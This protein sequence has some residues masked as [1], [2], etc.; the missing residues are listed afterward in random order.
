MNIFNVC[1]LDSNG[2]PSKIFIFS[3]NE[4]LDPNIIFSKNDL[5]EFEKYKTEYIYCSQ[6][7]YKDDN[8]RNI[9]QKILSVLKNDIT[10]DEIYL[11]VKSQVSYNI[12]TIFDNISKNSF[13]ITRPQFKQFIKNTGIDYNFDDIKSDNLIIDDLYDL[14]LPQKINIDIP[15]GKIFSSN[16]DFLFSAN[17]F[18]IFDTTNPVF[19]NTNSNNLI[20]F[21]NSLLHDYTMSNNIIYLSCAS[22]TLSFASD[23]NLST[24]YF[25]DIFFN[26][27]KKF[28][29]TN[30]IQLENNK[31]NLLKS[32]NNNITVATKKYNDQV[33]LFYSIYYN[34]NKTIDYL[35]NGVNN[36]NFSFIMDNSN[37]LPLDALFKTLHVSKNMPFIKYNPGRKTENVFRLFSNSISKNGKKM[38]VISQSDI[39][40][41]SKTIGKNGKQIAFY[42]LTKIN[43]I[44]YRVIIEL[45][46]K[47]IFNIK[48]ECDNYFDVN[49][50][51]EITSSTINPII[52]SINN[53]IEQYGY[54]LNYYKTH[55]DHEI[56]VNNIDF[57]KSIKLV[58]A[59]QFK[60][61]KNF[62]NTLFTTIDD[63][64]PNSLIDFTYKRVSNFKQTD[65]IKKKIY[66]MFNGY[67]SSVIVTELIDNFKITED[68]AIQHI[69]EFENTFN[70]IDGRPVNN[71][72]KIIE[73]PG[74]KS[75]ISFIPSSDEIIFMI[76]DIDSFK[77][78]EQLNIY[79]DSI[80]RVSQYYDSITL[81]KKVLDNIN[82]KVDTEIIEDQPISDL[83][84]V[85]K[86]LIFKKINM[87]SDDI[88]NTNKM[89]NKDIDI[90]N[91]DEDDDDDEGGIL[92]DEDDD[93]NEDDD[94]DEGGILFDDDD[95]EDNDEMLGGTGIKENRVDLDGMALEKPNLFFKKLL[96][97]EPNLF[98][99]KQKGK[100]DVYSRICQHN[101]GKQPVILTDDEKNHI[102]ENYPDSYKNSFQYGTTD[103]KYHYI[104]PK[105]WCLKTNSSMSEEDVKNGKCG[106]IIPKNATTIPKG[107]YVM[108]MHNNQS[109]FSPGFKSTSAHPD[110]KCIPCCFKDWDS[111]DQVT[112]RAECIDGVK[113]TDINTKNTENL[114]N[115]YS[116]IISSESFVQKDRYGFLSPAFEMYLNEDY[117]KK[118]DPDNNHQI[119][120][121]K[122]VLLRYGT[123]QHDTQSFIGCLSQ[124]HNGLY[125]K[126]NDIKHLDT[127]SEFKE[128]M[129][130]KITIDVFIR[131]QNGSLINLFK[132]KIR[133]NIDINSYV[134]TKMYKNIDSSNE[135]QI[136]F[137][138]DVISSYNHFIKY[139]KDDKSVIDYT[140]LWDF[141]SSNE[142]GL[143][144]E[145]INLIVLQKPNNDMTDN[146]ELICPTN[147]YSSKLFDNSKAAIIMIKT[148]DIYELV[149][150]LKFNKVIRSKEVKDSYFQSYFNIND[151]NIEQYK[152]SIFDIIS[153]I[154]NHKCKPIANS[155]TNIYKT[156]KDYFVIYNILID[157]GFT[158]KEQL[159]NYQGK[160]IALV[161]NKNYEH[162]I[163]IPIAPSKINNNIVV[164]FMDDESV[165]S[166]YVYTRDI[167]KKIK[168]TTDGKILC[169]PKNKIIENNLIVGILTETNQ[170]IQVIPPSENIHNDDK[171]IPIIKSSNYVSVDQSIIA[172]NKGNEKRLDVYN[173]INLES[174]FYN[175]F[176]NTVKILLNNRLNKTIR[177]KLIDKIKDDSIIYKQKIKDVELLIRH[178]VDK[179]INFVDYSDESLM[180][181]NTVSTCFSDNKDKSYCLFS[182]TNNT[183]LI[184]DKHLISNY[185]NDTIYYAR[186]SDELIRYDN[187]Q[188]FILNPKIIVT[189][190]NIEYNINNDEFIIIESLLY[191]DY[192][193]N[194]EQTNN[195][196]HVDNITYD[197]SI[198]EIVND[199]T[200]VS[201]IIKNEENINTDNKF[202]HSLLSIDCIKNSVIITKNDDDIWRKRLFKSD[203]TV[204]VK[205]H[206]F[207]N[208]VF[209]TFNP[210]RLIIY[211]L[212]KLKW[213]IPVIKERI[214]ETYEKYVNT[215]NFNKII[216]I[217]KSQGK[218]K[219]FNS[220]N[221]A[222][223]T[224]F[225]KIILDDNYYITDLDIFAFCNSQ[226]TLNVIL[227]SNSNFNTMNPNINWLLIDNKNNID[228]IK[229]KKYFFIRTPNFIANDVP[230]SYSLVNTPRKIQDINVINADDINSYKNKNICSFDTFIN[231]YKI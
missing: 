126:T 109:N 130:N 48:I 143:F 85:A 178:F 191:S 57:L 53:F 4:K 78:I 69:H 110:G 144:Q 128:K 185:N 92:F 216:Q 219:L 61:Y 13:D 196:K 208:T 166:D 97:K 214:L 19:D 203:K 114:Q 44:E 112:R 186:I 230:P 40:K 107:H 63:S 120:M 202:N 146:I 20:T 15:L 155:T 56:K 10:Y 174:L 33:D 175:A 177:K 145:G 206:F 17:P 204:Q 211:K 131:L 37:M 67:D 3:N 59:F 91:E 111:K 42:I 149:V 213:T 71:I 209:C 139:L 119:L 90:E 218:Q 41:L 228:D 60:K 52:K 140:Y 16:I 38:P 95:M 31:K 32:E 30:L 12:Q 89:D 50:I 153:N 6:Y 170:F 18:S 212:V 217:L 165:Y 172:N 220:P 154:T 197:V 194:I 221:S 201:N 79:I 102:D 21:D 141:I 23:N 198:P 163:V 183:L 104:C 142:S 39:N 49:M 22:D 157:Y 118:K 83:P 77:Y 127:I 176:R 88:F 36:I 136:S 158:V 138:K 226:P 93:D 72:D 35:E 75:S 225:K 180:K 87:D 101:S 129:I 156:N 148:D 192:F 137:F 8:I 160:C 70:I 223:E 231:N 135:H 167:L 159:I 45:L 134:N 229:N 152:S 161:V 207:R 103:K 227:F 54:T 125:S 2:N 193:D 168:I 68:E 46:E 184:P 189:A 47:S 164:K 105:Y 124:V 55:V 188:Q 224:I 169:E 173:R 51:D 187:M 28:D 182:K 1:L 171:Q 132:P 150:V 181:I 29:I 123:E 121:N 25:I 80:L 200:K 162:D 147:S 27:L 62:I 210:I 64:K 108:Q 74:F 195:N 106:K 24:E 81:S 66:N 96:A 9:K 34:N 94:D 7:I 73:N 5:L 115:N 133:E 205:E 179:N 122:T 98:L 190:N 26:S 65:A 76:T 86:P 222:D 11:F 215:N 117:S 43:D 82:K 100:F 113:K 84:I 199:E 116:Y 58:K 151:R 14:N 99:T